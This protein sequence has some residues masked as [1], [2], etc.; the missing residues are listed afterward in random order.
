M[1]SLVL[2]LLALAGA[3]TGL[4]VGHWSST[5]FAS[6]R[7]R[8]YSDRLLERAS[9]V[10]QAGTNSIAALS[11]SPNALCSDDDLQEMRFRL[12]QR[13][14][15]SDIGRMENGFL[16]CTAAWGRFSQPLKLPPPQRF[17]PS[18]VL[19]WANVQSVTD[20][21]LNVDMA[22]RGN[23]IVFTSPRAFRG[24]QTPAPGFSALI[25]THDGKHVFRS[26]GNTE[27]LAAEFAQ[28][29]N[30]YQK[31]S[32]P[33]IASNCSDKWDICVVTS[34]S[35]VS[36][37][38]QPVW[39]LG[40]LSCMGAA[41]FCSSGL[42]FFGW[43]SPSSLPQQIRSAIQN[44]RLSAVY[45]PLVHISDRSLIGVE[46]LARLKDENGNPISPEVFIEIAEEIGLITTIT[47]IMAR[48]SMEDL[49]SKL[50]GEGEFYLSINVAVADVV[51]PTFATFLDELTRDL[52]IPRTRIALELTE[53]S[54]T[55]YEQLR[56]GVEALR[57]RGYGFFV[58]DFGT[59]YSNL[60][61]LAKLPISGIKIDR[62]FTQAIGKE[63]VS[64]AIVEKICGIAEA[65]RVKLVVEGIETPDQASHVL[66]LNP[67]AIGQGWLFGK[68]AGVEAILAYSAP[69]PAPAFTFH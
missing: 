23:V 57:Q 68:P 27:G 12:F 59:G 8:D 15:L 20:H 40:A 46:A 11:K 10:A 32:S 5:G 69:A 58:D 2:V 67:E 31:L 7:L 64:S 63:A 18:G 21:R 3:G 39:I 13:E 62:M 14:Y 50:Q 53:R 61:H 42:A 25:L 49:R 43:N 54:T 36:I 45:Q 16:V 19:L 41:L 26:F 44:G 34:L 35:G 51:D 66:M 60:S 24:Y 37:L 4:L 47:R 56:G 55:D 38:E 29:P 65:L 33:L 52:D 28:P 30:W 1:L 6:S 17:Q 9:D 22:G 48:T